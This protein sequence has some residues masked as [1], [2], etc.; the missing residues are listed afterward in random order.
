[1][2]SFLI[3]IAVLAGCGL[4]LWASYKIEPHWV[5]KDG[6]RL[7]CYGQNLSRNG[8]P[9]GRFREVRAA[10]VNDSLIEIRHKARRD[11]PADTAGLLRNNVLSRKHIPS[12]YWNV[13]G[14]S[15]EPPKGKVIFVL[16]GN[17]DPDQPPLLALRVPTK[18]KAIPML[19]L[20]LANNS[21][22][23]A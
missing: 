2:T 3:L 17:H 23:S 19:D 8:E 11:K 16:G 1:M 22:S 12:S 5:S 21:S 4:M 10:R 6:Q 13:I 15:P 20:L 14:V 7:I 9:E 18:S